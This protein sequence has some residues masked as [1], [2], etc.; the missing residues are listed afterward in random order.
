MAV[1]RL[2]SVTARVT[3]IL[4]G[5]VPCWGPVP[6][7][8]DLALRAWIRG[9]ARR[10]PRGASGVPSGPC[11]PSDPTSSGPWTCHVTRRA[12]GGCPRSC[13][14][15][16]SARGRPWPPMSNVP[17]T[18]T[19]WCGA[20]VYVCFDN[21]PECIAMSVADWCGFN[22]T[23]TVCID[24]DRPGSDRPMRTATG[25]CAVT[26]AR[27]PTCPASAPMTCEP[28]STASTPCPVAA[29]TGRPLT[30]ST[31]QLSR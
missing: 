9:F 24:P 10:R 18:P 17:S 13:T 6:S 16:T 20:P 5:S 14:S 31:L 19:G 2:G 21:G 12:M 29:S 7:D 4:T 23:G 8:D 27:A 3:Q 22:G 11:A 15:L 28:S 25:S 1:L 26:S 30:T